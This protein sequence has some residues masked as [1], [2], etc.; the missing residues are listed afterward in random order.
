MEFI[1]LFLFGACSAFFW[2]LCL[3]AKDRLDDEKYSEEV[4]DSAA[5]LL[6][7]AFVTLLSLLIGA[8]I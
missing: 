8:I 5:V 2:S 1:F 6:M 7:C 4:K 3:E